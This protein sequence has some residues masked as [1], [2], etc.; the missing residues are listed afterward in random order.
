MIPVLAAI[1]RV[2]A[3]VVSIAVRAIVSIGR[4][5]AGIAVRSF[6]KAKAKV[7]MRW[8]GDRALKH[9]EREL[10]RRLNLAGELIRSQ[11][12][13]NLSTPGPAASAPGHF[14]HAQSGRLRAAPMYSVTRRR[15]RMMLRVSVPVE[16]A[17]FLQFGASKMQARPF[18]DVTLFQLRPQLKRILGRPASVG[19]IS[20]VPNS[21]AADVT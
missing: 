16:Y 7:T 18:L 8:Y 6:A 11:L 17:K 9:I 19:A 13:R 4:T 14:P 21:I 1:G 3:S 10:E 12:T 20:S 15:D 5:L 2:A